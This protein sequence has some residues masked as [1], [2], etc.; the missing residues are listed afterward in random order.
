LK[1]YKKGFYNCHWVLLLTYKANKYRYLKSNKIYI[2]SKIGDY[3][4]NEME[5]ICRRKSNR[6]LKE[7]RACKS[8][9]GGEILTPPKKKNEHKFN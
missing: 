8:W 6:I 3:E 4:N 9:G 7:A 2:I 1:K 5:H